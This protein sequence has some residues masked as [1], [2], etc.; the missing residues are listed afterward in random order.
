M[1]NLQLRRIDVV[2]REI[3]L[4]ESKARAGL[5]IIPLNED[6]V[7]SVVALLGRARNLGSTEP[8][9]YLIPHFSSMAIEGKDGRKLSVG[10]HDRLS[11]RA[12]GARHDVF[13]VI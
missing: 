6:A 11:R 10:R 13:L 8:D 4:R 9:H 7:K 5:C 12:V 3:N 2:A 1:R